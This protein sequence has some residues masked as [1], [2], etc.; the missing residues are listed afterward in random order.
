MVVA[1]SESP[2]NDEESRISSERGC[3]SAVFGSRDGEAPVVASGG[4]SSAAAPNRRLK[5][6]LPRASLSFESER[7]TRRS[8][9][10][11]CSTWC[12]TRTRPGRPGAGDCVRGK[13]QARAAPGGRSPGARSRASSQL[14]PRRSAMAASAAIQQSPARRSAWS[15]PFRTSSLVVVSKLPETAGLHQF[16]PRRRRGSGDR[17]CPVAAVSPRWARRLLRPGWSSP[18]KGAARCCSSSY[19][20]T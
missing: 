6:C 8:S 18:S 3:Q 10:G 14:T 4:R 5:T 1:S 9:N 11:L 17:L 15:L 7:W 2:P 20:S 13:A 12:S 19:A 16:G